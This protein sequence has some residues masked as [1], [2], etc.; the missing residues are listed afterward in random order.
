[1]EERVGSWVEE[2]IVA[3]VE[4]GLAHELSIRNVDIDRFKWYHK[5]SNSPKC[6]NIFI[7]N[8]YS[9]LCDLVTINLDLLVVEGSD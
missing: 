2:D 4:E 6:Q 5:R 9:I 1:M 3:G 7:S 8:K